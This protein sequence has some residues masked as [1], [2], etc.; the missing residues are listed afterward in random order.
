MDRRLRMRRL[1]LSVLF[2]LVL[3]VWLPGHASAETCTGDPSTAAVCQSGFTYCDSAFC[4]QS[5]CVKSLDTCLVSTF[6]LYGL[7]DGFACV[8][9]DYNFNG[10]VC[11]VNT[12]HSKFV[13][14]STFLPCVGTT[15]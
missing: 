13:C 12:P 9:Y 3:A 15:Y 10:Y 1:L 2:G 8:A 6:G 4:W 14:P 11:V 7:P 5:L